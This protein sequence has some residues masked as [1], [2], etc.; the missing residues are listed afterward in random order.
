MRHLSDKQITFKNSIQLALEDWGFRKFSISL[1]RE[2]FDTVAKVRI[3]EEHN[4]QI[5]QTCL[6]DYEIQRRDNN[7]YELAGCNCY[8]EVL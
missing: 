7:G 5:L 2:G 3:K 6:K 1:K 4:K 8:I